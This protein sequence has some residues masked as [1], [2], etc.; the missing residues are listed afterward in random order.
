MQHL[1]TLMINNEKNLI[2]LYEYIGST[3][4]GDY[5][6]TV[7]DLYLPYVYVDSTAKDSKLILDMI[8]DGSFDQLIELF[9]DYKMSD[10]DLKDFKK[11]YENIKK[12]SYLFEKDFSEY[13]DKIFNY[14]SLDLVNEVRDKKS[15][16]YYDDPIY[17]DHLNLQKLYND[18]IIVIKLM[19]KYF[20]YLSLGYEDLISENNRKIVNLSNLESKIIISAFFFTVYYFCNNSVFWN[21]IIKKGAE[22]ECDEEN[23]IKQDIYC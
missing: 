11:S 7:N 13:Y 8:K 18:F 1:I 12:L 22:V 3:K 15:I 6:I 2:D 9:K 17:E 23:L 21:I 20:E 19:T 14:K 4:L 10:Q 16:N 5:T